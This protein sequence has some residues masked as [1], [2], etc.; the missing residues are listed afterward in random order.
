MPAGIPAAQRPALPLAQPLAQAALIALVSLLALALSGCTGVRREVPREAS[1][2]WSTPSDTT[3]GRGLARPMAAGCQPADAPGPFD[4]ATTCPSGFHLLTQGVDALRIR[5]EL[6]DAARHTLDLQYYTLHEDTTTALLLWRVLRAAGRGVRV[7]LLLDDLYAAGR[8]VD[9]AALDAHPLIEVRVFNPFL[10]RGGLGLSR[11]L[12]FLGDPAR[13]NRRMH[14][15]LWI[16]DNAAAIVG[17]RN[18]GDVYF[19]AHPG[20]NFSD[21][22]LLASGPV[23]AQLSASFDE[24]WNSDWA[25][26]ITA[27]VATTPGAG[28]L[29][30]FQA[31][32]EA[33]V[34]GFRD[35]PYAAALREARILPLLLDG[36][37]PL[38][39]A[40][41]LAFYDKP[42]KVSAT[43]AGSDANPVF[44]AHLRPA[45]QAA[46]EEVLLVSPYFIPSEQGMDMM[47]ALVMRGVRVRV[48]TNS[49]AATDVPAVHAGYARFR[50][51]LLAAGVEVHEM[52]PEARTGSRIRLPALPGSSSATSLHAKAILI[53]RRRLFTGSM[54]LD[55]RSRLHNT[56]VGVMIDSAE[57]GAQLGA[58]FDQAMQPEH[59]FRL[60]LEADPHTLDMPRL[61]WHAVVDGQPMRYDKEPAGFWRR[62]A[63]KLLGML[64]PA[65]LL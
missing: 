4:A 33:E 10:Q 32:L 27:F 11:L 49:L 35:T 21:L 6:A 38:V 42:D 52:R 12:E 43:T 64:A 36:R 45:I 29:A 1:L 40:P 2:A 17:G 41:A 37:M 14:N 48:L 26:P 7:R 23:V 63:S 34:Q 61:A 54:N 24:Y 62:L 51:R 59:T 53:D 56:E 13:L 60:A 55:P 44:Q 19:E 16:A 46:R 50:L 57:V 22:D 47:A 39:Q 15:K 20:V 3:L 5:A 8:D 25:V 58:L 30:T 28:T 18:L 9:L 65:D 31:R